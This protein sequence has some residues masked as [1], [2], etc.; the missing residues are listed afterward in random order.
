MTNLIDIL[1]DT[2]VLTTELVIT[3]GTKH[4]PTVHLHSCVNSTHDILINL[5]SSYIVN[6]SIQTD[7]YLDI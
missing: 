5:S 4:P 3:S 7:C 2:E 6:C 1:V